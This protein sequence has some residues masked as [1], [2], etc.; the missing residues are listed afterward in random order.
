MAFL[1]IAE[2]SAWGILQRTGSLKKI[3]FHRREY[4]PLTNFFYWFR[5]IHACRARLEM[6]YSIMLRFIYSGGVT[7]AFVC[8]DV[9]SLNGFPPNYYTIPSDLYYYVE[10]PLSTHEF[11]TIKRRYKSIFSFA[12]IVWIYYKLRYLIVLILLY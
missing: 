8:P 12:R 4:K 6:Q 11:L 10:D 5:S 7:K 9:L 3:S 2:I 1:F